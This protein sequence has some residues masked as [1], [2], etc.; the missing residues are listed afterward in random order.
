MLQKI[1]TIID[2]FAWGEEQWPNFFRWVCHDETLTLEEEQILTE[3]MDSDSELFNQFLERL[4]YI[5][6]NTVLSPEDKHLLMLGAT[7]DRGPTVH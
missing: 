6:Q 4:E 3:G 5:A 2:L 1:T 7:I